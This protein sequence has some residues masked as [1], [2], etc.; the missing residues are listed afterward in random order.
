MP[1]KKE[2]NSKTI[3]LFDTYQGGHR[4][5]YL[6]LFTKVLLEMGY[7]V[8]AFSQEPNAL[9]AWVRNYAADSSNCLTVFKSETL[10][11]PTLPIVGKLPRVIKVLSEWRYAY[12]RISA[13]E[14]EIHTQVDTVFFPWLDDYLSPYLTPLIVDRFF[15][16]SW[17]GLYLTPSHLLSGETYLPILRKPISVYSLIESSNCKGIALLH[18]IEA[19]SLQHRFNK[20]VVTFPDI[21]DE[22]SPAEDFEVAHLVLQKAAGRT[23]IGLIG[24]ITCRK[25][26]MTLLRVAKAAKDKNW[27]FVFAGELYEREI[28]RKDLDEIN[29]FILSSPKNC[30]FHLERIPEE[31]QFN[32][33]INACNIIFAAYD[34]F[35][36]SSNL[37]TKAAIFEKPVIV[38]KGY[39]M[40]KRVETFRMGISIPEKDVSS[41]ISAIQRIESDYLWSSNSLADF[42]EYRKVHSKY[43]LAKLLKTILEP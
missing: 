7:Q 39:C 14:N 9:L 8:L 18:E 6:R 11:W 4:Q 40:A 35:P 16:Y 13:A 31:S 20:P 21:T 33:L 3:A 25:G 38:S 19:E 30:L 26:V 2:V 43:N 32:A 12:E 24:G 22:V 29:D 28:P 5:T 37:L 34:N 36:Y 10:A 23:V 42:S 27:F 15:S 17:A 41:C 1:V